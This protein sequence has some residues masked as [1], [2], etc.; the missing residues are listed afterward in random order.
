MAENIPLMAVAF[1][2]VF[3]A[4]LFVRLGSRSGVRPTDLG[5]VS[6]H[7]VAA[8]RAGEPASSI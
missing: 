1:G 8:H 7:W 6:D 3:T 2:F 5:T 4:G